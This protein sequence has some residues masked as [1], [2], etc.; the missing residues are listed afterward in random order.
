MANEILISSTPST[1]LDLD[2][3]LKALIDPPVE[4]THRPGSNQWELTAARVAAG[5]GDPKPNFP[6]DGGKTPE[7][8]LKA[9][10]DVLPANVK[11]DA[12]ARALREVSHPKT[13]NHAMRLLNLGNINGR[14]DFPKGASLD[15]AKGPASKAITAQELTNI[16][17]NWLADLGLP[18]APGAGNFNKSTLALNLIRIYCSDETDGFLGSEAGSDEIEIGGQA[19]DP[20]N[21]TQRSPTSVSRRPRAPSM[22][23]AS[24]GHST[25][26]LPRH[27]K[28]RIRCIPSISGA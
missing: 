22:P 24:H 5:F 11:V 23:T 17:N 26:E 8:I 4:S 6:L 21:S 9:R 7:A 19:I 3:Q 16:A 2:P 15:I 13:L 20:T 10:F 27:L 25:T 1:D 18:Q 12:R 28:N 14:L